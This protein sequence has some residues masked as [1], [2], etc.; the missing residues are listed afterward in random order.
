VVDYIPRWLVWFF[1]VTH[2]V[3]GAACH[4]KGPPWQRSPIAKI[5]LVRVRDRV[6][7]R[8]RVRVSIWDMVSLGLGIWLWIGLGFAMADRNH[9]NQA[10]CRADSLIG[11]TLLA[12]HQMPL[13]SIFSKPYIDACDG[14][15]NML[16]LR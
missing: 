3:M 12:Q 8:V 15:C 10:R 9:S 13:L 7:D 14:C 6:T 16:C 11:S 5:R 1:M 4:R 2:V